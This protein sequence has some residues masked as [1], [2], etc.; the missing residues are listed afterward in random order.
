MPLVDTG[1]LVRFYIDEAPSGNG[2][3]DVLDASGNGYDVPIQ[4]AAANFLYTEV[5]GNRGLECD[6]E[7]A[8]VGCIKSINDTSD[9]LRDNLDGTQKATIETVFDPAV[10]SASGSRLLNVNPDN[11]SAGIFT[12]RATGLTVNQFS[13]EDTIRRT[14]D[15][16]TSARQV[17]HIV[18]NTTL[19]TA[20]DRVKVFVNGSDIGATVDSN[21]A[22]NDTLTLPASSLLNLWCRGDF[23]TPSRAPEGILFYAAIYN[24]AFSQANVTNNFDILTVDDDT[25]PAITEI[26]AARPA[27]NYRLHA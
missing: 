1:L 13:W 22:Q 18:I 17:V 5:S 19:A 8:A 27:W 7:G 25:P 6:L 4:Y 20:D 9:I 12:F 21:M 26:P 10:Y 14:W 11:A 24:T 2:P 15:P 16:L 3:T 23:A